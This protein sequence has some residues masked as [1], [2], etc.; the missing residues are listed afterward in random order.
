MKNVFKILTI[1]VGSALLFTACTPENYELGSLMDKSSLKFSITQNESDPNM[2]ILKSQTPGVTPQ[3]ITPVGN[4]VRVQDTVKLAFPGDYKFVYGVESAGGLVQA[5]TMIVKVTT[6]NLSYVNDPVWTLICGGVG[7][8]KTWL[9]DIDANGDSKHFI[10]PRYFCGA[11]ENWD[12]WHDRINGVSDADIKAKYGLSDVWLWGPNW[13]ETGWMHGD[14]PAADYGTMTF[15][16]KNGA[17]HATVNHL[18]IPDFGIQNGTF[19][20][21]AVKHT[22]KLNNAEILHPSPMQ[23]QAKNGW[24]D[25][26]IVYL[27]ENFMQINIPGAHALNFISKDF[28][29][30]WVPTEVKYAEPVKTTFTQDDLVGMWRYA[31]VAQNWISW[32]VSGSKS[33]GSLLNSWTSRTDMVAGLKGWGAADAATT[34]ANSDTCVYIFKAD[35]TCI[36]NGTP[37]TYSVSK[38]VVSFGTPL[39]GTEWSLVW[40]GM[41]GNKVNVLNVTK[42]GNDAYKSNGIWIGQRNGTK[43]ED[44]AIQL[45][46]Q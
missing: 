9:L 35:G 19:L 40:L 21:D 37:N 28:A 10:S 30:K 6:T 38:G 24:S 4:S 16:L 11:D 45:I 39:T 31:L 13:K 43:N 7:Q 15:D 29:D 34:F 23:G 27:D 18:T 41:T 36:L 33:G 32:E 17:A 44:A 14:M 8:E 46:K 25:V 2:I 26:K 3:W 1:L 42:I 5:D 22:L 12:T 20:V